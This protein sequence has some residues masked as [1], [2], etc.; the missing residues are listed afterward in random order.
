[1]YISDNDRDVFIVHDDI[2]YDTRTMATEKYNLSFS[3][4]FNKQ[5]KFPSVS[6]IYCFVYVCLCMHVPQLFIYTSKNSN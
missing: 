1:M 2:S 4:F 5:L 6:Y 3:Y